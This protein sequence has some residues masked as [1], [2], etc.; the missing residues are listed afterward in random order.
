MS[1]LT[2]QYPAWFLLLCLLLGVAYAFLLYYKE[3]KFR[4]QSPLLV[5]GLSIGRAVTVSVIAA[6]LLSPLLRS[7]LEDIRKPIIVIARD[8]SES[9]G[10]YLKSTGDSAAFQ[11]NI[12]K[13]ATDLSTDFEVKV[14][15]FGDSV[16]E[17][18][19]LDFRDKLSNISGMLNHTYDLFS[20]QNLGAVILATDGLYNE[21]A[22]PAYLRN[23]LSVPIFSIALGDTSTRRDLALKRAF[24]NKIAYLGDK[25]S[26]QLDIAAQNAAGSS[27][28]LS[29]F[30]IE[31][32]NARKIQE[33]PISIDKNDF[34]TTK[35]IVLE[36]NKSGV[37]RYRMSLSPI[38]GEAISVNNSKD[39]FIE[40]LDARQ[41]ILILAAAP[42]PDLSAIRQSLLNNKN[43]D[44]TVS[45]ISEFKQP[46]ADFDFVILHQLPSRTNDATGILNT[47]QTRRIPRMF[48]SGMQTNFSRL[49]QVQSLVNIRTDGRN[50]NEVQAIQAPAF[51]LFTTD[52]QLAKQIASFA[53]VIAPF[54]EYTV[55]PE[56]QVLLYQRI[57]KVDTKYP[58]LIMG[59]QAG[60]RTAVFCGEGLWKWRLFDFLQ[61]Q[62]HTIFDGLIGKT[63]QYIGIKDDKRKFRVNLPGAIFNENE[64]IT[65]D[66]EL[67]ND[68]YELVNEPDASLIITNSK[69]EEFK[70]T[71]NKS[72]KAY[73]LKPGV[74][75][76]GNYAF[77]AFVNFNGRKLD[78]EGKF[79]VQPI[80][81]ELFETTADH[82]LLRLLSE[83]FGGAVVYPDNIAAITD[84]IKNRDS[85]KPVIYNTIETRPVIH[86]KWLFFLLL[87]L[88][89]VE[90]FLRRYFGAY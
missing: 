15:N 58:L 28:T 76:T 27:T 42:H 21:G 75:P 17:D 67:Y 54:G 3:E 81:L 5:W 23:Q 61:N 35:D 7:M 64:A 71:F 36:A 73:N 77:K 65:F 41:K 38:A 26:V 59:E 37:L 50:S 33:I 2:F 51:S 6:L 82:G 4:E 83:R 16:R 32:D 87:G 13:L 45:V 56:A 86:L 43:Y 46:V 78:Y 22:N 39:I 53:P 34:F 14:Y 68:N 69:G 47:L 11:Q 74:F 9:V 55:S 18:S 48:I 40:V 12:S 88:I 85:V 31:G 79:S 25:F 57:G 24:H 62:Q 44:I 20:N 29:V 84:L 72:G 1:N 49:N 90:W 70:Y 8:A 63:V 60:V 30:S 66:A 89:S 80:Q 52:E 19:K 10:A